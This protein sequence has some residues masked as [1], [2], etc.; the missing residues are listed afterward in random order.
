MFALQNMPRAGLELPGLEVDVVDRTSRRRAPSSTSRSCSRPER[1][2]R[3]AGRVDYAAELF[4]AATIERMAAHFRTLL[5]CD[6]G[7]PGPGGRAGCRC[8]DADE[9][10]RLVVE[11]ER[12]A[13]SPIRDAS[14]SARSS[15]RRRPRAHAAIAVRDRRRKPPADATPSSNARANQLAH[16]LRRRLRA[17]LRGSACAWSAAPNL[18]VATARGAQGGRR[19]RAA[20]SRAAAP[21]GSRSCSRDADVAVV[22]T[23]AAADCSTPAG[24]GGRR[25]AA[26]IATGATIAMRGRL[27]NAAAGGRAPRTSAYVIYTSGS[28]GRPKGVRGPAPARSR[29]LGLRH[30]LRAPRTRTTSSPT[31]ANPAFDA[32]TF[33]IWGALLNG[34]RAG[35]GRRARSRCRRPAFA[36]ALDEYGITTLF[37]T[38]ALFNQVARDAPAAF[39]GCR[40]V[41]FGGEAAEPRWVA[42]G[43]RRTARPQRLLHVYGPTETTTFATWHEV[44]AV[45][46]RCDDDADRPAD[47]QHRGLRARRHAGAGAGRRAGRALHRRRRRSPRGYLE[48]A[49]S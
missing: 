27:T 16:A 17:S 42:R 30:G 11:R 41:L 38:T 22:V 12:H 9:R 6:R 46:E 47:R 33:E 5:G 37:L 39:R 32:S 28:T 25:D 35:R 14:C 24:D 26:S 3:L 29:R 34:A 31:I 48:R 7:E 18:V 23:D 20:R 36:A 43:A 13:P 19:L 10:R 44:R 21:S 1:G 2:G 15:S 8:Y 4:D 45:P 49:R 40:N